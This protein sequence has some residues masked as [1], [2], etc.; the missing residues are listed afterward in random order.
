MSEEK[1]GSVL[2]DFI[3]GGVGG[4]C[5]VFSGHPLDTIKAGS[6]ISIL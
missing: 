1:K 2:R 5:A 6:Q 4:I 3:A